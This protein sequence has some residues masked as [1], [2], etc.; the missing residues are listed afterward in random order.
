MTK[1]DLFR[2]SSVALAAASVGLAIAQHFQLSAILNAMKELV[3]N[4]PY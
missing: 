3:G 2:L 4:L 1:P